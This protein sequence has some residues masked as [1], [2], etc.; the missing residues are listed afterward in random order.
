MS[1]ETQGRRSIFHPLGMVSAWSIPSAIFVILGAVQLFTMPQGSGMPLNTTF[2][3]PLIP[4]GLVATVG[5]VVAAVAWRFKSFRDVFL[6]VGILF[7]GGTLGFGMMM[8]A[9][10]ERA[11]ID[12]FVQAK[13]VPAENNYTCTRQ[14]D[15]TMACLNEL[16]EANANFTSTIIRR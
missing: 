11:R 1:R 4:Y 14:A 2:W 15:G 8:F 13:P 5:F 6:S 3:H 12:E 10:A 7:G 16:G 9:L